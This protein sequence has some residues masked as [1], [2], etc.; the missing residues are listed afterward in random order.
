MANLST[1]IDF[2][3][4][5]AKGGGSSSM[6]F[7]DPDNYP[8][9]VDVGL[10][11][12]FTIT[13]PDTVSITGS[14]GSPDIS[15]NGTALTTASKQLRLRSDGEFQQG[16]YTIVYH[17]TAPGYDE[18][19]LTKTVV[20]AYSTPQLDITQDFDVFTPVLSLEDETDYGQGNMTLDNVTRDW[21]AT[22]V[23]VEGTPQDITGSN[24]IFDLSYLGSYYDS[25]YDVSLTVVATYTLDDDDDWVSLAVTIE[26]EATYYAFIPPS[27]NELL[28]LLTAYKAQVDAGNCICGTACINNCTNLKNTYALAVSIFSHI[29]ER[30]RAGL[31]DGLDAYV[32]Q[33]QK[34]LSN[35]VTPSYENTDE[36]IPPYDWG[37]VASS[38]FAFFKQMIVGSG[39]NGAPA[40]GATSYTDALLVGKRVVVFLDSLLMG[41]SLSDRLSITFTAGSGTITWNTT[42]SAPQL[43]SIFTY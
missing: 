1:Y 38:N 4:T 39:I 25:E 13:Q 31:T 30:G 26:F 15:W 9:G 5:L 8:A 3:V 34:L 32:I 23:T 35:C 14:Y 16:T 17:I 24:Q 19:T 28:D 21:E 11:G 10:K 18:T 41:I 6:L 42:L 40:D 27:L 36:A 22:I 37:T 7:S 12:Y 20:L 29:I 2:S 43:I 33:L